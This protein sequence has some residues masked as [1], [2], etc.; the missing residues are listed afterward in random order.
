MELALKY[1][2]QLITE[3]VEKYGVKLKR[4]YK[5]KSK[6]RDTSTKLPRYIEKPISTNIEGSWDCLA[7]LIHPPVICGRKNCQNGIAI[8]PKN[9]GMAMEL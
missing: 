1:G 7:K 9:D 8:T 2:K 5:R 4:K 3:Q 6:R